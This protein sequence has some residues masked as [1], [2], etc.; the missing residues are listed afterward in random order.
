MTNHGFK[1]NE[2]VHSVALHPQ[3]PLA[4]SAG[5]DAICKIYVTAT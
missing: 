4:A 1:Y 2:S 5:A 3:L